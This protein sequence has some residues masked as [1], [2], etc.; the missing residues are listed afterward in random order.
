MHSF[1]YVLIPDLTEIP[2]LAF[3]GNNGGFALKQPTTWRTCSNYIPAKTA[4]L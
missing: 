3:G 4:V 2:A 1:T